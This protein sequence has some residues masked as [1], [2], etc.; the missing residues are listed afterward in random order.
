MSEAVKQAG[1][2]FNPMSD[3]AKYVDFALGNLPGLGG[4]PFAKGLYDVAAFATDSRI[5]GDVDTPYGTFQLTESGDLTAPDMSEDMSDFGNQPVITKKRKAATQ[6]VKK[7]EEKKEEEK[8]YFPKQKLPS[9]TQSG[10]EALQ[11]AY[12]I[13][14]KYTLPDQ[15]SGLRALV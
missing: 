10:L 13:L 3:E 8:D 15:T 4:I 14:N 1:Y 11:Y 12:N 2:T 6:P 5:I 7:E 9:L